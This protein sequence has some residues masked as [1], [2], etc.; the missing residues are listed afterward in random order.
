[1][2]KPGCRNEE[3]ASSLDTPERFGGTTMRGEK[4]PHI[5]ATNNETRL[6]ASVW[7]RERARV[8][9][10]ISLQVNGQR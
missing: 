4:L 1:M 9:A 6:V 7:E 5:Q 2:A 3:T 10:N 8:R